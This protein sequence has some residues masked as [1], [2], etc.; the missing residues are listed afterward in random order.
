MTYIFL[1]LAVAFVWKKKRIQLAKICVAQNERWPPACI[2]KADA[3][4]NEQK[5]KLM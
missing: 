2:L 4:S 3:M 5:V 1:G